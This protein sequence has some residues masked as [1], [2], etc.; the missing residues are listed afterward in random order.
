MEKKKAEGSDS[1]M[2]FTV[3]HTK[4]G[5]IIDHLLEEYGQSFAENMIELGDIKSAPD[6]N[7]LCV[8]RLTEGK[9]IQ[10]MQM[11]QLVWGHQFA[12]KTL[13]RIQLKEMTFI[14]NLDSVLD[15]DTFEIPLMFLFPLLECIRRHHTTKNMYM[16]GNAPEGTVYLSMH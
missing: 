4:P 13:S 5:I 7:I 3:D 9:M 12:K 11:H 1:Q 10:E 8:C 16:V 15:Y 6:K 2:N 14:N